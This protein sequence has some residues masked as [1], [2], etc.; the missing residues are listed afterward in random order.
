MRETITRT[1]TLGFIDPKSRGNEGV[2]H[3]PQTLKLYPHPQMQLESYSRCCKSLVG[4]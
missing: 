2:L 3:I 4:K 1:A